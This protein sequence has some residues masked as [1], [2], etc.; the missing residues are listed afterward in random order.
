[1]FSLFSP[2]ASGITSYPRVIGK[3]TVHLTIHFWAAT[4]LTL[5]QHPPSSASLQLEHNHQQITFFSLFAVPAGLIPESQ[6][7]ERELNCNQ[8]QT[9]AA[10]S[11]SHSTRQDE[12][13]FGWPA[14]PGPA[15]PLVGRV[16]S[17]EV[18]TGLRRR[19]KEWSQVTDEDGNKTSQSGAGIMLMES[20]WL[21]GIVPFSAALEPC[22]WVGV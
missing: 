2:S 1:M 4:K 16:E 5:F 19:G 12:F 21:A 17:R 3:V 15:R 11:L 18:P 22:V 10:P 9:L 8:L 20:R 6:D 13:A 14:R 7:V